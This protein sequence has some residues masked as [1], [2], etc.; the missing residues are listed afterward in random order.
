M[1]DFTVSTD[2]SLNNHNQDLVNQCRPLVKD[3]KYM[4]ALRLLTQNQRTDCSDSEILYITAMCYLRLGYYDKCHQLIDR[5][6]E[7]VPSDPRW[8]TL[9]ERMTNKEGKDALFHQE[10]GRSDTVIPSIS[11][12]DHVR[13]GFMRARISSGKHQEYENKRYDKNSARYFGTGGSTDIITIFKDALEATKASWLLLALAYILVPIVPLIVSVCFLLVRMPNALA[14]AYKLNFLWIHLLMVGLISCTLSFARR[15]TPGSAE[16]FIGFKRI[17]PII[18]ATIG[19]L[20][21]FAS[22]LLL[23]F[24]INKVVFPLVKLNE[25]PIIGFSFQDVGLGILSMLFVMLFFAS[26]TFLFLCFSQ[27]FWILADPDIEVGGIAAM[28]R[29]VRIMRGNK[30]KLYLLQ[31]HVM[32]LVIGGLL[33]T[34]FIGVLWFIPLT[35]VCMGRFYDDVNEP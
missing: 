24:G 11:I 30:L 16:L 31:L 27:T 33:L 22:L 1:N 10:I 25:I 12:T 34:C 9:L 2:P 19:L 3:G 32:S 20:S 4:E 23:W 13:D 29:S 14:L 5:G 35:L 28:A 7:M 21:V 18:L 26:V 17:I 6:R 8:N 15:R